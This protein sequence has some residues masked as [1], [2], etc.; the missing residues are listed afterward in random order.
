MENFAYDLYQSVGKECDSKLISYGGSNKWLPLVLPYLFVR[1]FFYLSFN[2]VDLIHIQDGLLAPMGYVLA[3]IF[4]RPWVVIIHGL[5]ITYE[6]K[7]F[8]SL[9]PKAVAKSGKA[10][11]ISQA[12]ADECVKRG[13]SREKTAVIALGIT[14]D[15]KVKRGDAR[16]YLEE[17][18]P[19]VSSESKI[20]LTVGRLVER[21]GVAWFLDN[22]YPDIIKSVPE[23][24]YLVVGT[25]EEKATI[26]KIIKKNKLAG[27][28]ILTGKVD[29]ETLSA[30]YK[31]SDIFVMPNIPVENDVEGFGRVILEAS[32]AE[33]PAVASGIEGIKDAVSDG[34]NGIL[35][36][37]KSSEMMKE[38]ILKFLKDDKLARRFASNSRKYSMKNYDWRNIAKQYVQIYKEVIN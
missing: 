17:K 19:E 33:L 31:G 4:R 14:D 10:I 9:V 24:I 11:C 15:H 35:V 6:N 32:L 28:V 30:I 12:A 8:Q 3:K 22:V 34:N 1:A 16:K 38:E 27:K 23:A 36:P 13:V 20:L 7:L 37:T 25:G 5:D 18:Y 21:K 26:E 29:D 2:R